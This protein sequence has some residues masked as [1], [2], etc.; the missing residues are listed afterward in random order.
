MNGPYDDLQGLLREAYVEDDPSVGITTPWYN[1]I[2]TSENAWLLQ[3]LDGDYLISMI[4][5]RIAT[6]EI[7][8]A[9]HLEGAMDAHDDNQADLEKLYEAID[10][11]QAKAKKLEEDE[12]EAERQHIMNCEV[13]S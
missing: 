6:D 2:R 7:F 5:V 8:K 10:E 13:C 3:G 9:G 4:P 12:K 1:M 11:L